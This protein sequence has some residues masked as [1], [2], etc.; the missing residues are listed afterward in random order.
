MVK[1]L[2]FKNL[3]HNPWLF[4]KWKTTIVRNVNNRIILTSKKRSSWN[5]QTFSS[6]RLVNLWDNFSNLINVSHLS[7][8]AQPWIKR[9]NF[10]LLTPSS[11]LKKKDLMNFANFV[12]MNTKMPTRSMSHWMMMES[13]HKLEGWPQKRRRIMCLLMILAGPKLGS[14]L[15]IFKSKMNLFLNNK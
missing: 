15:T 14:K 3:V 1:P 11:S 6:K 5:H 9:M 7:K 13:L 12:V 10:N 8:R 4:S 2:W